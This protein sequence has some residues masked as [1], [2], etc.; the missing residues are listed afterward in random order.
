MRKARQIVST[1]LVLIAFVLASQPAQAAIIDGGDLRVD[2][3]WNGNDLDTN[4]QWYN[5]SVYNPEEH[6]VEAWWEDTDWVNFTL[7]LNSTNDDAV[8]RTFLYTIIVEVES[9]T[10]GSSVIT[11]GDNS[12]SFDD[13]YH[14]ETY[15]VDIAGCGGTDVHTIYINTYG[16]GCVDIVVDLKVKNGQQILGING[17]W[18]TWPWL[19]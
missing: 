19:W 13:Y 12:P 9:E 17:W 16:W 2:V 5:G 11:G 6:A 15:T 8:Q 10:N 3:T 4:T 7:V 14:E 18:W 1:V